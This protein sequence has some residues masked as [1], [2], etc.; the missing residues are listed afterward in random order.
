MLKIAFI[1]DDIP[2]TGGT[3]T[4]MFNAL[5]KSSLNSSIK[6]FLF[7]QKKQYDF[8]IENFCKRNNIC[9]ILVRNRSIFF[10]KLYLNFFYEIYLYFYINIKIKPDIYFCSIASPRINFIFFIFANK[11]IYTLHSIPNKTPYRYKIY[12][13]IL[14]LNLGNTKILLTVSDFA[15]NKTIINFTINNKKNYVKFLHNCAPE[16]NSKHIY[17]YSSNIILTVAHVVDYKNPMTWL[18]VAKETI[19]KYKNIKFIWLGD[20]PLLNI[21]Q[22]EVKKLCLENNIYFLGNVDNVSNFYNI[23]KVYFHPSLIESHGISILEAMAYGLP[24]IASNTSGIKESIVDNYNGYLIDPFDVI[25]FI[26][27]IDHL[28]NNESTA[29]RMSNNSKKIVKTKFLHSL[30]LHNM[31]NYINSLNNNINA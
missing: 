26:N 1:P 7:L 3:R 5:I 25:N 4:F 29:N 13:Y 10:Y 28:I 8:E 17:N 24:C 19:K 6:Y 31:H 16:I 11:L 2:L 9:L 15:R 20:G 23:S 21:M 22:N 30:F 18:K 27:K 12:D 14:N